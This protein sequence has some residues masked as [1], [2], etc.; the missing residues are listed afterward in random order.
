M[1]VIFG[2]IS[3]YFT[4]GVLL[5]AYSGNIFGLMIYAPIDILFIYLAVRNL[6]KLDLPQDGV[7]GRRGFPVVPLDEEK[8]NL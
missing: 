3:L 2:I 4:F 5:L 1:A 6:R 7:E 8:E